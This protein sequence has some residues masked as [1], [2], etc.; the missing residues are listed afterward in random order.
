LDDR[1]AVMRVEPEQID[2]LL[3]PMIDPMAELTVL[4]SGLPASP[5]AASGRV[6][7]TAEEAVRRHEGGERVLLVRTLTEPEDVRGMH[8]AQG[9]LTA[10]GGMTSHAA[11]VARG[12]GRSCV[13]GCREL[14]INESAGYCHVGN[15]EVRIGDYLTIDGATGQVIRGQAP[16]VEADLGGEFAELMTWADKYRRLG[17]RCNADTPEDAEIARRFGAEGVGLCRT[18]HM[19]FAADRIMA[20]RQMIVAEQPEPRQEALDQLLPMQKSDFKGIFRAMDGLPVTVRLLDPPLHEFLP[21]ALEE[22]GELAAY[23]RRPAREVRRRVESLNESNPMLGHRGC[24]LGITSPEIYQ[25][26]VRAILEAACE[27]KREGVEVFPEIMVPLVAYVEELIIVK[28]HI[29]E[30]AERVMREL[31]IRVDYAV[32]TMME[33]PRASFTADTIAR[34]AAFFSFGTNDLTQTSLGLSRDDA[35]L[36]P[37]VRDIRTLTGIEDV[38]PLGEFEA[39][40][41]TLV[42]LWKKPFGYAFYHHYED[43]SV[44]GRARV[45]KTDHN[46]AFKLRLDR[47]AR[48]ATRAVKKGFEIRTCAPLHF[49]LRLPLDRDQVRDVDKAV[50]VTRDAFLETLPEIGTMDNETALEARLQ[51]G[52]LRRS[53]YG[54]S[55]PSIIAGGRNATVLHYLKNDEPLDPKG[56][57]LMD[58]GA[59]WGTM[60]A[61]ITRVVPVSG[62]FN[63]LQALIYGIVLDAAKENQRN[64]K[65]GATI[66]E[67]N[68]KVWAFLE[69]ALERRFLSNGGKAKRAYTGKPH[70]VSHLMGEQEHDG[71]PHRIYQDHPLQPGWQISNEPGLYGHFV[72]TLGGKRYAEWIGIRIED[73][74]LITKTGW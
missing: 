39:W 18:E 20:V 19:F 61:D 4:A 47:D 31:N 54:L 69:D 1:E 11:V 51:Y 13:V 56:L 34:E 27:L 53:P 52:M 74:L 24:R 6:V 38:R 5:G 25:M 46:Y 8:A 73:D 50:A 7:F 67:L 21:H 45:T 44:K 62:R 15:V 42:R 2:Q 9:I 22:I 14:V 35:G 48:T 66:R 28:R 3:H 32:G 57:V 23:M 55:F 17:V 41:E 60:H 33:L 29:D 59:R 36:F 12:M 43:K 16:L 10:R 37:D 63:P 58:F 40:F 65:P 26:Q 49:R 68:D 71:D 72:I 70:G 64:A 30:M